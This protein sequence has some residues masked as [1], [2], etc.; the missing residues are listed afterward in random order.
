MGVDKASVNGDFDAL[1]NEGHDS[2]FEPTL[3]V[4]AIVSDGHD[5]I[6]ED[7]VLKDE[8]IH[9]LKNDGEKESHVEGHNSHVKE[10][11]FKIDQDDLIDN[12]IDVLG[13]EVEEMTF[14]NALVINNTCKQLEPVIKR[15]SPNKVLHDLVSH[16]VVNLNIGK[17]N[18]NLNEDREESIMQ[19][20]E[21]V[22]KQADN[23]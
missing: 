23:I 22:Y 21:K 20:V 6:E 4:D 1:G 7:Q 5:V 19:N 11:Q 10:D 15:S 16:N 9:D 13:E 8:Q 2:G 18:I 17:E 14:D 3:Q 12:A